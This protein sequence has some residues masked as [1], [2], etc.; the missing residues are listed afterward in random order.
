MAVLISDLVAPHIISPAMISSVLSGVDIIASKI[1]LIIHPDK[2]T[3]GV[4]KKTLFI[5][6]I[7]ITAGAINFI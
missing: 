4:L 6:E 1:F 7:S 3:E 2:R 5:M